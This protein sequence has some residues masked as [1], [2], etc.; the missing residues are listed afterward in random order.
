MAGKV[1]AMTIM[2]IGTSHVDIEVRPLRDASHK[3]IVTA[4][5]KRVAWKTNA[6]TVNLTPLVK[7]VH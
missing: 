2:E 7:L 6:T 5:G 3:T 4:N 1:E